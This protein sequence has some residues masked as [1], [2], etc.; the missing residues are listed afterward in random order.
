[1]K[2]IKGSPKTAWHEGLDKKQ[3][4]I[5]NTYVDEPNPEGIFHMCKQCRNTIRDCVLLYC[6]TCYNLQVIAK[7]PEV[8]ARIKEWRGKYEIYDIYDA[9]LIIYNSCPMC[10]GLKGY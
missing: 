7:T 4:F 5:C 3:C 2:K 6:Q 10:K 1:M 9:I 8:M